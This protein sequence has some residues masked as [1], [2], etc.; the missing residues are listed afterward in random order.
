MTDEVA[1]SQAL[2]LRVLSGLHEGA[3]V[4][5]EGQELV[6]AGDGDVVL[7]DGPGCRPSLRA[8]T[9]RR[10]ALSN[11]CRLERHGVGGPCCCRWPLPGSPGRRPSPPRNLCLIIL[12]CGLRRRLRRP[13]PRPRLPPQPGSKPRPMAPPRPKLPESLMPPAA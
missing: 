12:S 10:R 2:Q 6:L 13:H 11:C 4:A 1:T 3:V 8:G 5:L 9:G 7:R